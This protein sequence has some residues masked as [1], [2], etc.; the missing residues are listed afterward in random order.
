MGMSCTLMPVICGCFQEGEVYSSGVDPVIAQF[1]LVSGAP[2]ADWQ[3]WARTD[4]L[5]LH[6]HDVRA[7]AVLGSHFVSGGRLQTSSFWTGLYAHS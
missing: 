7:I 5:Q 6:T 4:S 3:Q 1:R 2:L